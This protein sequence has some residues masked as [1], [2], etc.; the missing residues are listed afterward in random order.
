MFIFLPLHILIAR[1]SCFPSG[2]VL[3]SSFSH[4]PATPAHPHPL[5]PF[6]FSMKGIP[7]TLVGESALV[8]VLSRCAGN[9]W[10]RTQGNPF[11][12]HWEYM[13]LI[14]FEI[15][16]NIFIIRILMVFLDA[17]VPILIFPIFSQWCSR[18]L[19]FSS[20]AI[21][22]F[23]LRTFPPLQS[24]PTSEEVI[25]ANLISFLAIVAIVYS[26]FI[27]NRQYFEVK[28]S[29]DSNPF[30]KWSEKWSFFHHAV[31]RRT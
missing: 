3:K 19:F 24:E 6:R 4:A 28:N 5:P 30:Q 29:P 7:L 15:F 31:R 10:L 16:S 18:D 22:K 23:F 26:I 21:I 2:E 9:K 25:N 13:C 12:V 11:S 17:F 20:F 8:P 27:S 1:D 14:T